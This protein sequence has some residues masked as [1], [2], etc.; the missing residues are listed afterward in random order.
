MSFDEPLT[1]KVIIN[2]AI[3]GAVLTKGDT[4]F[5]PVSTG[6][7]V[8]CA[9]R[10]RDAGAAIVHL[11]ARQLDQSPSYDPA[12]YAEIVERIRDVTDL[13]VCVSLSGRFVPDVSRRAAALASQPDL[14]SLT[15]G[16]MNFMTQPSVNAPDTIRELA[17]R[18]YAAGAVPELEVFDTGFANVASYLARKDVLRAPYYVNVILGSLGTAPMDLIGLGHIVSLLP[19]GSIWSVGGLGRFQLDANLLALAAGGHIR[20][21][22]E[23]NIYFDRRRSELADNPRLVDRIAR[24]ARDIGREPA[25]P[26]E[27][28]RIIGLP[29]AVAV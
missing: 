25:T 14:A 7:I 15:L 4:A 9:Q 13:V 29:V 28:R 5:L 16:S 10:V 24:V 2:A 19:E 3:T 8:D 12:A 23:D 6:E 1:D 27:A 18:I 26:S 11:H 22:L 20:V 17:T 21:G